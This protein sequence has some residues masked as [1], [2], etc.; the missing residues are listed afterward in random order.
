MPSRWTDTELEPAR[1][2]SRLTGE[3]ALPE[4]VLIAGLEKLPPTGSGCRTRP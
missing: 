2:P 3:I 4:A 1:A